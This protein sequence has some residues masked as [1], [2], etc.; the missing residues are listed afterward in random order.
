MEYSYAR[1]TRVK[2][3]AMSPPRVRHEGIKKTVVVNFADLCQFMNRRPEH[4]M[5]FLL[6]KLGTTGSLDSYK[7]LEVNG[8]FVPKNLEGIMKQYAAKTLLFCRIAVQCLLDAKGV[9]GTLIY[10]KTSFVARPGKTWT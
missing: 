1:V 2:T 9:N 3:R 10:D 5:R 4:V 7:K 6:A 8:R